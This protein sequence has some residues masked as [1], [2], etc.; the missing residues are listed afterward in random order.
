MPTSNPATMTRGSSEL[1]Y[2]TWLIQTDHSRWNKT[3]K[4]MQG[5]AEATTGVAAS[6]T[7]TTMSRVMDLEDNSRITLHQRAANQ[8]CETI[9]LHRSLMPIKMLRKLN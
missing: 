3:T 5:A 6:A 8:S 9:Q 7:I 1:V 4:M 2:L